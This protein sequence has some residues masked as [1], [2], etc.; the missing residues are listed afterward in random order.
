VP[1]E[2]VETVQPGIGE[3]EHRESAKSR[4][5]RSLARCL[6]NRVCLWRLWRR[7]NRALARRNT[8]NLLKVESTVHWLGAESRI[9]RINCC[10]R[11]QVV[12]W[13]FDLIS[14]EVA[15]ALSFTR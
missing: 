15:D 2:I 10:G 5:N 11:R 7:S 12:S 1:V 4:V 13:V 3:E 8:G 14:A 6:R 9:I